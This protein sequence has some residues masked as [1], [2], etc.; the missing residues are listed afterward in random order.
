M[1]LIDAGVF[2]AENQRNHGEIRKIL[3]KLKKLGYTI[4]IASEKDEYIE[5][6]CDEIV[7]IN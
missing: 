6:I 3:T 5:Q 1:L 7:R 2:T 4:G